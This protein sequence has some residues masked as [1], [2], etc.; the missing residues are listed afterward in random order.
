MTKLEKNAWVNIVA[1]A[2]CAF[3]SLLCLS[4]M[5]KANA[6]GIMYVIIIVVVGG[7]TMLTG[8][9]LMNKIKA[10]FDEREKFIGRKAFGWATYVMTI[11]ALLVCLIPFFIIG[12]MGSVPVY[13][14][15]V[16]LFIG[17]FIG[18]L[19]ESAIILIM[20]SLEKHGGE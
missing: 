1:V 6:Q 2:I 14:L 10:T 8:I 19:T 9:L 13:Y 5:R 15:P 16:F 12:G 3:I 18:Q 11:Y 17:L 20:C 4:F 7:P